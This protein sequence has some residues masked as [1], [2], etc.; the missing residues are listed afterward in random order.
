MQ[1]EKKIKH[2]ILKMRFEEI[3]PKWSK[4]KLTRQRQP[5]LDNSRS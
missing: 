4:K 1:V 3:S 2:E 5:L